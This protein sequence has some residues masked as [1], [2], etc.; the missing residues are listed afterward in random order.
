M[1]SSAQAL[2]AM[3]LLALLAPMPAH[4]GLCTPHPRADFSLLEEKSFVEPH[5]GLT[6]HHVEFQ[7]NLESQITCADAALCYSVAYMVLNPQASPDRGQSSSACYAPVGGPGSTCGG[8]GVDPNGTQVSDD[9]SAS[10]CHHSEAGAGDSNV[11]HAVAAL[12][13]ARYHANWRVNAGGC[14]GDFLWNNIC[15]HTPAIDI[16]PVIEGAR[17][18]NL[19]IADP[20]VPLGPQHR[21]VAGKA[22]QLFLDE[23][24]PNTGG[25]KTFIFHGAGL[26]DVRRTIPVT[27][28]AEFDDIVPTMPGALSVTVE[29]T[30]TSHV[31]HSC[32]SSTDET[33]TLTSAPFV[34]PVS[35]TPCPAQASSP[36][37]LYM[38]PHARCD[39]TAAPDGS[40]SESSA[41]DTSASNAGEG[42]GCAS[43]GAARSPGWMALAL[44][45]MLLV[46]ARRRRAKAK[47]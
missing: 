14:H 3:I 13:G 2:S 35:E 31:V 18:M 29:V 20:K 40:A 33:W 39:G 11:S 37:D 28:E 19:D 17:L 42:T 30:G 24:I 34:I 44:V 45:P 27:S 12:P 47:R 16:P 1:H 22:F 25:Q 38:D 15:G 23:R 9:C 7:M 36:A 32:E 26:S 6:R 5:T 21:L 41:P 8:G 46:P 4:A 43:A 10:T